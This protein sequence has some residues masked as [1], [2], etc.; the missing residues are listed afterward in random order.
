MVR[1]LLEADADP[2]DSGKGCRTALQIAALHGC[3]LSCK[4]LLKANADVNLGYKATF[5]SEGGTWV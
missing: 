4:H 2:N 1:L 3:E 5:R